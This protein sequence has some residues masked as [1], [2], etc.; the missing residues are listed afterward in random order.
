MK[1]LIRFTIL[2]SMGAVC[3]VYLA[4]RVQAWPQRNIRV[5][6]PLF[7]LT[8]MT[9]SA[10]SAYAYWMALANWRTFPG[11]SCRTS[12]SIAAAGLVTAQ[13][14]DWTAIGRRYADEVYRP[15]MKT[16]E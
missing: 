1:T 13:K 2:V 7:E 12:T 3:A 8:S 11:Q 6:I 15:L 10:P 4:P 14:F 5:G 9:G 16:M